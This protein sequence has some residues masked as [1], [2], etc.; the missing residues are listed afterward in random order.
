VAAG[1]DT[2]VGATLAAG[3]AGFAASAGLA[4]AAGVA[5]TPAAVPELG[6]GLAVLHA[7]SRTADT[8]TADRKT[9]RLGNLVRIDAL[10]RMLAPLTGRDMLACML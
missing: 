5:V 10:S 2:D 9:R 3:A 7:A 1:L 4:A 6:A 8:V